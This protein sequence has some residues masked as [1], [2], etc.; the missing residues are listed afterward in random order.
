MR[1]VREAVGPNIGIG[2][3]C[4]QCLDAAGRSAIHAARWSRWAIAWLEEPVATEDARQRGG[5]A[6]T[7]THRSPGT[8]RKQVWPVSAI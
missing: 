3:R 1:G 4:Q 6:A 7:W 8:R 2:D 5:G